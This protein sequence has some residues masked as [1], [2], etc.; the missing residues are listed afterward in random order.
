MLEGG[1]TGQHGPM[2]TESG[3]NSTDLEKFTLQT[4]TYP[5]WRRQDLLQGGAKIECHAALTVDFTA[6]YSSCSMTNGFVT[7][8]VGLLIERA[9]SC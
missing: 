3:R 5:Q 7:N 6:R 2:T 1:P 4:A 8:A 9:V